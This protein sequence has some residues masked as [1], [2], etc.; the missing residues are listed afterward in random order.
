MNIITIEGGNNVTI[1]ELLR[2]QAGS[3][4][5]PCGGQG[6]CGKCRVQLLSGIC[7]EPDEVE[8]GILTQQE[9]DDGWRLAC[10][11]RPFGQISVAVPDSQTAPIVADGVA[12]PAGFSRSAGA[13]IV[14]VDIGTTTVE[15]LMMDRQSG[16]RSAIVGFANPQAAW[17]A[18]VMSRISAA[19]D[20]HDSAMASSV[21]TALSEGIVRL[22]ASTG[23]DILNVQLVIVASNTV[24]M[25]LFLGLSCR[26]LGVAPFRAV[27]LAPAP[28]PASQ[29]FSISGLDC[30]VQ[31][32]PAIATFTGGD[33]TAGIV[34][35]QTRMTQK[36]SNA[37][38][39]FV[40]LGTNAEM[41]LHAGGRFWCLSAPAGPAFEGASLSCGCPAI[42]GA[43]RSVYLS[44]GRFSYDQVPPVK[45][46]GQ[47]LGLCGSGVVGFL[48][49]A[50]EAGLIA[51]DGSVVPACRTSGIVLAP[52][53]SIRLTASDVRELLLARAAVRASLDLLLKAAGCCVDD[54][55]AVYLAGSFGY[56]LAERD[57]LRTGL[58]PRSFAGRI[59]AVGNTALAGAVKIATLTDTRYP[60][61]LVSK[62]VVVPSG[63]TAEFQERFLS[64]MEFD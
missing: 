35:I 26:G 29:L 40:D 2:L 18:D 54:I 24:M 64:A 23:V 50:L 53:S 27:T 25:H 57:V 37:V 21:R 43:V 55:T 16:W 22:C 63:G 19:Q 38:W 60:E 52:G 17:G 8:L 33:I 36:Q 12:F 9:R 10:R 4:I 46:G 31:C 3:L 45:Q 59:I 48:S 5:A 47:V 13:W 42:P 20:G 56:H 7:T 51:S 34:Y 61:F 15:M 32:V 39:L 14:A 30:P 62:A 58:L 44:D 49:A 11:A 6:R 28:V 41:V 1:L